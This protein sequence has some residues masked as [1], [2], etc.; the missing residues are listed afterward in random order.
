LNPGSISYRDKWR[1]KTKEVERKD[2]EEDVVVMVNV[3][4]PW[5]KCLAVKSF[6]A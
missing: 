6:Q 3:W 5:G 1:A 2:S 4:T